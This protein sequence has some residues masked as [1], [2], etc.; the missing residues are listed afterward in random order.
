MS[1]FGFFRTKEQEEAAEILKLKQRSEQQMFEMRKAAEEKR[2]AK[3][4]EAERLA[5]VAEAERLRK[6]RMSSATKHMSN[7]EAAIFAKYIG[8]SPSAAAEAKRLAEE[9]ELAER[10]RIDNLWR[11]K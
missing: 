3:V 8:I 5:E 4:A 11:L 7:A 2:L 6:E 1:W 10:R 9:F